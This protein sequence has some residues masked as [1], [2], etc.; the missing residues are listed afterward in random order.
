MSYL[1]NSTNLYVLIMM[2]FSFS[3]N[4]DASFPQIKQKKI[5]LGIPISNFGGPFALACQNK[6]EGL[7]FGLQR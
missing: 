5:G 3:M 2:K 4:L 7:S 1:E 6:I